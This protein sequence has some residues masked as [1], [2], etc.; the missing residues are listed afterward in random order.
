MPIK[1]GSVTAA[2][3]C[4]KADF[5]QPICRA[6]KSPM[7][8]PMQWRQAAA[9]NGTAGSMTKVP[10]RDWNIRRAKLSEVAFNHKSRLH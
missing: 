2:M 9:S 10:C 1:I 8:T 7:L 4:R 3:Q 6:Q 5:P